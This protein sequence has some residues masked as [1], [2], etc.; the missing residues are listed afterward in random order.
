MFEDISNDFLHGQPLHPT[1]SHYQI[2]KQLTNSYQLVQPIE[3]ILGDYYVYKTTN[4]LRTPVRKIGKAQVVSLKDSLTE[5]L[6]SAEVRKVLFDP[7]LDIPCKDGVIQSVRD[8][9]FYKTNSLC[10]QYK[11]KCLLFQFYYDDVEVVNPLGSYTKTHKLAKFYW[12]L[13]NVP[14]YLRSHL[15]CINL[16]GSAKSEALKS[17]GFS[18]ILKDFLT[19]IKQMESAEGLAFSICGE[20]IVFHG[21]LVCCSADTPA[22]NLLGGFKEGVGQAFRPCRNCM[23]TRPTMAESYH[24]CEFQLRTMEEL[25]EQVAL[26]EDPSKT[27]AEI[28]MLSRNFGITQRS[29]FREHLPN[30]NI[31]QGLCQDFM[32]V[33]YEGVA[34]SECKALIYQCIEVDQLFTFDDLNVQLTSFEYPPELLKDKPSIIERHHVIEGSLRQ[35][36]SQMR[37]LLIVLPFVLAPY[38]LTANRYFSN[39]LL[40]SKLANALMAFSFTSDHLQSIEML[41]H[42]HHQRFVELYPH[43]NFTP[44]FHYMIHLV[45]AIRQYGPVRNFWCM[46]FEGRHVYFNKLASAVRNFK[47]IEKTLASRFQRKRCHQ[48]KISSEPF[49]MQKM[50]SPK[51]LREVSL[52]HFKYG[53][54]ISEKLQVPITDFV[55]LAKNIFVRNSFFPCGGIVLVE[56]ENEAPPLFG[57]IGHVCVFQDTDQCVFVVNLLETVTYD[58]LRNS[59]VITKTNKVIVIFPNELA[60]M[61]VFPKFMITPGRHDVVLTNYAAIEYMG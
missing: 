51:V 25:R 37:C 6:S 34:P 14:E 55:S 52:Q 49:L 23:A 28:T 29:V 41:I 40:L 36:A 39:F 48:L 56:D 54:L 10:Q 2:Q 57:A 30:F 46:R 59:Y 19:T 5:L 58:E 12:T 33:V 44:K 20:D 7:A 32:H 13:L 53:Q 35:S 60:S 24:E 22:A 3:V 4:G 26:I 15:N 43:I 38:I 11:R 50:F 21:T 17:L 47:C 42:V 18:G 9:Q 31:T 16:I 1:S 27:A 8:G 45:S 61:Q